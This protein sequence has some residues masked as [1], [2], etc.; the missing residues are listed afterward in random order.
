[1]GTEAAKTMYKRSQM[2]WEAKQTKYKLLLWSVGW[3]SSQPTSKYAT[4]TSLQFLT[5]RNIPMEI[6]MILT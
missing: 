6:L 4:Y 5:F 1:M 3:S 2:K